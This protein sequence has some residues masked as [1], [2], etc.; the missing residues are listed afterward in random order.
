M[1]TKLNVPYTKSRL[2]TNGPLIED[3]CSGTQKIRELYVSSDITAMVAVVGPNRRLAMH[4]SVSLEK[5]GG[6]VATVLMNSSNTELAPARAS[7]SILAMFPFLAS[8]RDIPSFSIKRLELTISQIEDTHI[9][10]THTFIGGPPRMT[11]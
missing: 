1:S 2:P 10:D 9:T 6:D 8:R 3:Y 11:H 4:V 7:P 5:T